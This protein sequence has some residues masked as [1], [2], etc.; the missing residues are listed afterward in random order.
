MMIFNGIEN[1]IN[2]WLIEEKSDDSS[3]I[4]IYYLSNFDHD[5]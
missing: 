5:Q 1:K 4:L 3:E 2:K